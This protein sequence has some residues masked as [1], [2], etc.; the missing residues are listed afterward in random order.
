MKKKVWFSHRYLFKGF[1]KYLTAMEMEQME[2]QF[3]N[4]C[5]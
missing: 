2:F 5:I 1:E 3:L 4:L